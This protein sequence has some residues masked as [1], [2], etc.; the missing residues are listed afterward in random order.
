MVN[1]SRQ[2]LKTW[3]GESNVQLTEDEATEL[4]QSIEAYV[5]GSPKRIAEWQNAVKRGDTEGT[6]RLVRAA[7]E[8]FLPIVKPGAKLIA[9]GQAAVAAG[10]T[11]A[12]LVAA[13]R[14]PLPQGGAGREQEGGKRLGVLPQHRGIRAPELNARVMALLEDSGE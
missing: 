3:L 2:S 14:K 7:T 8:I 6:N 12:A 11:K 5:D 10:K 9:K 1:H 13:T 4:G